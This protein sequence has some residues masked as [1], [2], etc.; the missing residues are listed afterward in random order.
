MS[1]S[2]V[3]SES[4]ALGFKNLT[5][6]NAAKGKDL[7]K[8]VSGYAVKGGIT[9]I[10]GASA[11]G[12]SVLL[13]TLAGR[14]NDLDITGSVFM[15]GKEVNPKN[16]GNPST[17]MRHCLIHKMFISVVLATVAYVPQD[18]S[19]IGDLT[20]REVTTNTALFKR[21]EPR[22]KIDADVDDLLQKLGLGHVADGIIG[23][24]IFVRHIH[25]VR[26]VCVACDF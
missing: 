8:G 13:Q 10:L 12:K 3:S 16:L 21:N 17:Y 22:S 6:K 23:T 14:M 20:A 15:N 5:L 24:L 25:A 19:L 1:T 18:D 2:N 7:L 4:I 11:S 26:R 9:A